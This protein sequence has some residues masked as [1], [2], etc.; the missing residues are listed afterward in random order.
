M[1]DGGL[2]SVLSQTFRSMIHSRM[3]LGM[4]N[5]AMQY[6]QTDIVLIE[7]D[8]RDPELYMASTFSYSQRRH[9]AEHAYQQTRALLRSDA[10]GLSSKLRWHGIRL[11]HAALDDPGRHLTQTDKA[12]TRLGRSMD[13]LQQSLNAVSEFTA[14]RLAAA[15]HQGA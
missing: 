7:P 10:S 13:S 11:N 5:Y 15:P 6:P 4:R 3:E 12:A 2:P 1:V 8:H 9:L 14:T